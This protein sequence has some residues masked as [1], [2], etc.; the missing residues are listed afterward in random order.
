[1]SFERLFKRLR[2]TLKH[3]D[4][5]LSQNTGAQINFAHIL[6]SSII[7]ILD[8]LETLSLN[9]GGPAARVGG[10]IGF[11][12]DVSMFFFSRG[13]PNLRKL[14]FKMTNRFIDE[15]WY[16]P[17]TSLRKHLQFL[18]LDLDGC[19]NLRPEYLSRL[20]RDIIVGCPALEELYIR[21][22]NY[23]R[24]SDEYLS[25]LKEKFI[26]KLNLRKIGIVM[27]NELENTLESYDD[28]QA[29]Q[30]TIERN[31]E[32]SAIKIKQKGY[33]EEEFR[34][35]CESL[36]EDDV[37][38]KGYYEEYD[39]QDYLLNQ[40][41]KEQEEKERNE[42]EEQEDAERILRG[43]PT[44]YEEYE[45][46]EEMNEVGHWLWLEEQGEM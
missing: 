4:I 43:E 44:K 17:W 12:V 14:N 42:I 5:D 31:I 25:V 38:P 9:F 37:V 8:K 45:I 32:E 7:R 39:E 18:K 3:L 6:G 27:T 29:I 40:L 23:K 33:G 1:V 26:Q 21:L 15:Q 30:R 46:L 13:L 28:F 36:I 34:L 2:P 16:L 22:P 24:F 19:F 10:S 35:Y 20:Q 41:N 11:P